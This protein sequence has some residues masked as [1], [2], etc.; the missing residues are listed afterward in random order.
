MSE[1]PVVRL[2]P[3]FARFRLEGA[4]DSDLLERYVHS[5]D[6]EA[7]A[8]LVRRHGGMVLAVCRR[9]LRNAADAEDAFQAVFLVLARRAAAIRRGVSVAPWLH[10]VAF[11]TS[12]EALRRSARRL[13]HE[14]RVTPREP[15]PDAMPNDF[16]PILDAELDRLP[17]QYAEVLVLCDMEDRPRRE[18]AAM[19]SVPEGTI[20]SRLSRARDMLADRLNRRGVGVTAGVLVSAMTAEAKSLPAVLVAEAT[21]AA[22]GSAS[23]SVSELAKAAIGGFTTKMKWVLACVLV[24]AL[25]VGGWAAQHDW[26]SPPEPAPIPHLQLAANPEPMAE[27]P[28][29]VDP[30]ERAKARLTGAWR[31]ESGTK[32]GQALTP[33]EKQ[34]LGLDLAADGTATLQ[35]LQIRDQ[36]A[37]TWTIEN[38]KTIL[39]TPKVKE[40][41]AV[42]IPYEMKDDVLT[43]SWSDAQA[44]GGPRSAYGSGV[45]RISFSRSSASTTT[46]LVVAPAAQNAVGNGLVGVWEWDAELNKKLGTPAVAVQR[47]TFTRDDAVAE[48]VPETHRRL[49]EG[50]RIYL[51]GRIRTAAN[52]SYRFLLI[53]HLGNPLLVYF[54][55][56]PGDEWH[57]EEAATV[58]LAA[59]AKPELNLLF[60]TPFEE[61]RSLP[62][63]A[64][65]RK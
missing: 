11:R 56:K 17:R 31:V 14:N 40:L 54:V 15:T 25:G 9:I 10:G 35:R 65:R 33:W 20:A 44:R 42:R 30:I 63:G 62:A 32:D 45:F 51:A 57:C 4:A 12:R 46:S 61:A 3:E 13:K 41:A 53:E 58:A 38:S 34:G 22:L 47:L 18:V 16:R 43:L 64:F 39:F 8:E 2:M 52:L 37:F 28:P 27:A 7:F 59:G 55:P 29:P 23:A 19:L 49:F 36:R 1:N 50:K 60:L 6:E 21:R 24:A 5:R 26:T 48:E